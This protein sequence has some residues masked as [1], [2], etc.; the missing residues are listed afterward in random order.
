MKKEEIIDDMEEGWGIPDET[1]D[2]T[3]YLPEE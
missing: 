2:A 3:D 1:R